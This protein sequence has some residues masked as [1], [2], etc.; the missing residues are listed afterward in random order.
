MDTWIPIVERDDALVAQV[1]DPLRLRIFVEVEAG[2][3]Q[4]SIEDREVEI[5]DR[6]V[7]NDLLLG[8][9][10]AEKVV[11]LLQLRRRRFDRRTAAAHEHPP[12]C[13][14][15]IRV[16]DLADVHP[17]HPLPIYPLPAESRRDRSRKPVLQQRGEAFLDGVR[18]LGDTH[19]RAVVGDAEH[20]QPAVG[21][22]ER[23]KRIG[24]PLG[25]GLPTLQLGALVFVVGDS[26][27]DLAPLHGVH[28]N[29]E[30]GRDAGGAIGDQIGAFC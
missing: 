6:A 24:H 18:I 9:H 14:N 29:S 7:G 5:G 1:V 17:V 2:A 22:G 16:A 21:I 3:A 13:T 11:E 19:Q 4:E 30:R 12:A 26:F 15:R 10:E 27:L 20:Q 23:R 8:H 28:F 25:E